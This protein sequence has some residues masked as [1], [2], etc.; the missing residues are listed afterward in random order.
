MARVCSAEQPNT[1]HDPLLTHLATMVCPVASVAL[2][3][4]G[5]GGSAD[6]SQVAPKLRCMG[7][8]ASGLCRRQRPEQ[9]KQR[10]QEG[11]YTPRVVAWAKAGPSGLAEAE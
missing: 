3:S 8:Q 1:R 2:R 6:S 9:C 7:L 11:R 5:G 4:R 10:L